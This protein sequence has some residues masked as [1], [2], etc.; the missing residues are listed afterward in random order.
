MQTLKVSFMVSSMVAIMALAACGGGGGSS[1]AP[2][3]PPSGGSTPSPAPSPAPAPSPSATQPPAGPPVAITG[4]ATFDSVPLVTSGTSGSLLNY[5]GTVQKPVR[6]AIV[7]AVDNASQ[8][9]LGTSVTTETGAYSL[10]I[11]SN[12]TVYVRVRAQMQKTG[13]A[14][15]WD[16]AVRDNTQGN[17]LY[18]MVSPAFT[19]AAGVIQ[20]LNA[21]SGWGGSNNS[22]SYASTRVAGPFAILD[23]VYS[24]YNKVLTAKG[25]A[26]FPALNLY[27][28]SNNV[29][30]NGD[31]ALGQIGTSFFLSYIENNETKREIYLLGAADVDTDEYDS[32]VV[33]HEW[34]HYFQD[35]FSRDDS[36]GGPHT[37]TDF[38]DIRVAFSE[39]WG[40]AWSGMVLNQ[41]YYADSNDT[42]QQGGFSVDLSQ[43]VANA[44]LP[45]WYKE[46]SVQYI[47]YTLHQNS[48]VG[49]TPIFNAMTGT[50]RTGTA[51]TT[52]HSFAASLTDP[53]AKSALNT[54]LGAQNIGQNLD[55]YGT[56]ETND[57]GNAA[58]LP[59]YK[60]LTIN[61]TLSNQCLRTDR[62]TPNKLGNDL[63]YKFS[64]PTTREYTIRLNG[65]TDPDFIVYQNG[66]LGGGFSEAAGIE[67][68]RAPL[69]AGEA[70]LIIND[71]QLA[72]NTCYTLSVQ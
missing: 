71:A 56:N 21:P 13:A 26:V 59:V 62:G 11:P 36:I 39:G 68:A 52:I 48:S 54:L 31:R 69:E 43:P 72:G 24:A 5:A 18:T 27:W 64:V 42:R 47:L 8:A 61:Q 16:F 57:S 70:V 9:V 28:S 20:N 6:G 7:E 63:F 29:P 33:A 66:L 15:T 41:N 60:A 44:S 34:G 4:T 46:S 10:S 17:A 67:E 38:L 37:G 49:F 2:V 50:L 3:P 35:A 30:A 65:G 12:L 58:N 32:P 22:G 1:P 14:P 55:Q 45:G 53:T 51:V 25:D 19:A 40:N 23:T